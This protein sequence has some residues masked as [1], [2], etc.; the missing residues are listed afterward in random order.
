[1]AERSV[2]DALIA[3]A[4]ALSAEVDGL[5]RILIEHSHVER[6]PGPGDAVRDAL[7][8]ELGVPV[9]AIGRCRD[10]VVVGLQPAADQ[11][12]ATLLAEQ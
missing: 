11:F 4:R 7:E 9:E 2:A 1:M 8:V 12:V 6:R 10:A 5:V 3:A